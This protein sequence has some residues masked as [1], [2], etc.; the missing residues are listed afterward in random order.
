MG[1]LHFIREKT[2]ERRHTSSTQGRNAPTKMAA[3]HIGQTVSNCGVTRSV[4][5][6]NQT[7]FNKRQKLNVISHILLILNRLMLD[8]MMDCETE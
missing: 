1:I 2:E 4:L 8:Y 3:F 6:C 7:S 5:E